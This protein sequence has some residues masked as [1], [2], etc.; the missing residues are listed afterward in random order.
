MS[1]QEPDVSQ[2]HPTTI[3]RHAFAVYPA[4]AML[5]G[6]QLD[7]FSPLAERPMNE[8]TLSQ[9]LN[10]MAEKLSPLLYALVSAGLLK[11]EDGTFA[12]TEEADKYL[13]R[14]RPQYMGGVAGF[15]SQLWHA[16]LLTGGSIRTGKP[17]AN[18]DWGSLSQDEMAELL[19]MLPSSLPAGKQLAK[20]IDFSGFKHLLDAG[21][22]TGELSIAIC[23]A[24]PT[25]R[26]TV[27]DLPTA[28]PVT[29]QVISRAGMS[30]RI[31]AIATDLTAYPPEGDY[32]VAVTR[33]FLQVLS[34]DNARKALLNISRAMEPG[35]PLYITD[36][37]L[38]D[39]KLAP[40]QAVNFN[41]AFISIYEGGQVH[42]EKQH[43]EW[44]LEAGFSDVRIEHSAF[45]DGTGLISAR[46]A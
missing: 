10:V 3:M 1:K 9:S 16:A 15:F 5:A 8:E 14:G 43:R 35:S 39:S 25:L 36:M 23:K 30:Q 27:A 33:T 7:V 44:L 34:P 19:K 11:V 40:L 6:M 45:S 12:N 22:G 21:G 17:Q 13:V 42:T 46:K 20:R 32:D 41:L 18:H 24:N 26:A 31:S 2:V 29:E 28:V 4:F 38:E 37:F